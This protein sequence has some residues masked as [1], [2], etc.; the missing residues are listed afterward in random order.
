MLNKYA[1]NHIKKVSV[2]YIE[3]IY[4][5]HIPSCCKTILVDL[6]VVSSVLFSASKLTII[7]LAIRVIPHSSTICHPS[8]LQYVDSRCL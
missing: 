3:S 8:R 7:C 4:C 1:L 6:T 2:M 5:T